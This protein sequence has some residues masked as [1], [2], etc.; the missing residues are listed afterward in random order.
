MGILVA[1][2]AIIAQ[3]IFAKIFRYFNPGFQSSTSLTFLLWAA[4]V[5]EYI[6]YSAVK[7]AVLHNPEFDEPTDAM[8][9]MISASLGFAAIEN[10]LVLF[11]AIP[12]GVS[13]AIHIWILRFA[14]ATLLHAVSSALLGY[15]LGM[16]WFYWQHNRKIITF[17]LIAATFSHFVFNISLLT[18]DSQLLGFIY[19]S[20]ALIILAFLISVL[21]NRLR[22]RI[23]C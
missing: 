15:F 11:Q 1:P 7:I 10:V 3:L 17:G 22:R 9:Y 8:V 5:E 18:A 19:S 6:K 21:F 13:A 4:F 16:S 12:N 20:L 2:S 23:A 14:G